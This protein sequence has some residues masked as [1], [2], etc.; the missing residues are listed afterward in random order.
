MQDNAC[1]SAPS[2][3]QPFTAVPVPNSNLCLCATRL[4][5]VF[6]SITENA[7]IVA[8]MATGGDFFGA[9]QLSTD[10]WMAARDRLTP[11][12]VFTPQDLCSASGGS[13]WS[14]M[15]WIGLSPRSIRARLLMPQVLALAPSPDAPDDHWCEECPLASPAA[16]HE[17]VL[18]SVGDDATAPH[19]VTRRPEGA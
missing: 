12:S 16:S 2:V 6:A 5:D 9:A 18:L 11:G 3:A 10:E 4:L 15:L 7:A 14:D 17:E 13:T 8:L 19:L 1:T